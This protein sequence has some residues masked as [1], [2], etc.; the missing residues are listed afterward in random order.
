MKLSKLKPGQQIEVYCTGLLVKATV[1]KKFNDGFITEHEPVKWG[2]DEY[3]QTFVGPSSY[4]QS[5]WGG[6]DKNGQPCKGPDTTPG[7]FYKGK[8]ITT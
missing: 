1:I 4:L 7:S 3:T 6:T 2:R 8:P 5:K